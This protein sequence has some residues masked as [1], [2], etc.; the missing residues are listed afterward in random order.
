MVQFPS[1][2]IWGVHG[3]DLAARAI[4]RGSPTVIALHYATLVPAWEVRV[5]KYRFI[6]IATKRIYR[7]SHKITAG[8]C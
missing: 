2:S 8:S 4:G 5:Y 3:M 6:N 7:I 1:L